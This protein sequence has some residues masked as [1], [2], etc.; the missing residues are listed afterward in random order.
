M[1]YGRRA[2]QPRTQKEMVWQRFQRLRQD[3]VGVR[4]HPV[5]QTFLDSLLKYLSGENKGLA[6]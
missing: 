3:D 4:V 1:R 6:S 2:A 5:Y